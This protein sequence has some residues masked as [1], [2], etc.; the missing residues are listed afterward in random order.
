[1]HWLR[2]G[3]TASL[4]AVVVFAAF[5]VLLGITAAVVLNLPA[6]ASIVMT[7]LA[8]FGAA[9]AAGRFRRSRR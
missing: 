3:F 2:L 4:T 5:S 9:A 7:N 6:G 8:L 1:L